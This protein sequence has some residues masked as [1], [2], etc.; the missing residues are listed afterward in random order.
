M[1]FVAV[2][3]VVAFV[4]V[5]AVVEQPPD[6]VDTRAKRTAGQLGLAGTGLE[7][8]ELPGLVAE[9][10]GSERIVEEIGYQSLVVVA[11]SKESVRKAEEHFVVEEFGSAALL[12]Q[13]GKGF[14]HMGYFVVGQGSSVE[15][16]F[17]VVQGQLETEPS[18]YTEF[19]S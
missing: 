19:L 1:T 7:L 15:R 5:V 11:S 13:A 9:T 16:R 10:A 3:A 17:V 8:I 14:A 6:Q 12:M 4:A 2:V 18:S